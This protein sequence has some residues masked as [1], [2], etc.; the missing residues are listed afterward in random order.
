MLQ[1]LDGC[2]KSSWGYFG[3]S[4]L[5]Q[6][7]VVA[8]TLYSLVYNIDIAALSTIMLQRCRHRQQIVMLTHCMGVMPYFE[9]AIQIRIM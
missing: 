5:A 2:W 7:T 8:N 9:M 1:A 6:H 3:N 4:G